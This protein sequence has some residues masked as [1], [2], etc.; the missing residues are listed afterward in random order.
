M[1]PPMT[2]R[3]DESGLRARSGLTLSMYGAVLE[4]DEHRSKDGAAFVG[5]DVSRVRFLGGEIAGRNDAWGD[6]VNVRGIHLT[7][8]IA[9]I[10]IRDVTIRG[11]S[12]NGVGV[13]GSKEHPARDV[14][15]TDCVIEDCCNRYGDYL[16]PKPGPEPGERPRGPGAR[17]LLF[18]RRLCR[19]RLPVRQVPVGRDAFLSL[20]SGPV[21][22]I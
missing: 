20:P 1:F 11:L 6:G 19:Q 14:W 4:L 8:R 22:P 2:Y 15:V 13:F 21:R 3:L 16:S 18:R 9:D 7:G 17:L 5:R 12:S 10:R